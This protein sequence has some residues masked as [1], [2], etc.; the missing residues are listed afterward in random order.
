MVNV[1]RVPI[2]IHEWIVVHCF[3]R[4]IR[5]TYSVIVQV[6]AFVVAPIIAFT[7]IVPEADI[8]RIKILH[9][10]RVADKVVVTNSIV[11]RED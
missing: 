10:D 9:G 7:A 6:R 3:P 2:H 1:A 8:F 4:K 11:C 5:V